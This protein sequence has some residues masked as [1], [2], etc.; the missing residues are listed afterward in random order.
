MAYFTDLEQ[1]F[2]KYVEQKRPWIAAAIL[3][4][5][6]TGGINIPGIKLYYKTTVIKAVWYQHKNGHIDQCDRIESPEIKPCIYCQ[7][8]FDEGGTSIKWY[9][10]SVFNKW[11]K[12]I[13]A[14]KKMKRLSTYN[15][16]QNKLKKDKGLK[17]KLQYHKNSRGKHRQENFR[18]FA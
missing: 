17:Y 8:I 7:L 12:W 2:Q 1:I 10:N 14:C 11:E 5:N 9:I 4:K 18:Y 15:I 16:H 6:K 3:K 13:S